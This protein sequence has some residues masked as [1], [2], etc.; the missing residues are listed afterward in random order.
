MASPKCNPLTPLF[1]EL[2]RHIQN[3]ELEKAQKI[4]NKILTHPNGGYT[5]QKA[6]QCKLVCLIQLSKFQ[7][8]FDFILRTEEALAALGP[9]AE[10]DFRA[11][12]LRGQILYRLEKYRD[13]YNLYRDLVKNSGDDY[14]EERQTNLAAC[15]AALTFEEGV[16]PDKGDTILNEET[17]ELMYNKATTLTAQGEY[18]KALMLLKKSEDMCRETLTEEGSNEEEIND[19]VSIVLAQIGYVNQKMGIPEA[20]SKYYN[21]V[22][23]NKPSDVAVVAVASNNIISL[24]REQN[25][26]DSKK[27]VKACI[28]ERVDAKLTSR[29]K[30][31]IALNN[32]LLNYYGH[33]SSELCWRL[34][35]QLEALSEPDQPGIVLLKAALF[36]RDRQNAKACQ[37]L[38]EFGTAHPS[39]SLATSLACAQIYFSNK[40]LDKAMQVLESLGDASYTAGIL[41][42]LISLCRSLNNDEQAAQ[43]FKRAIAFHKKRNPSSELLQSLIRKSAQYFLRL[44]KQQEAAA[45][46]QEQRKVDPHNAKLL[47][48]LVAAYATFDPAKAREVAKDLPA[49]DEI[50]TQVD[51]ASLEATNWVMGTR[52]VKRVVGSPSARSPPDNQTATGTA[53]IPGAGDRRK[54]PAK[55]KK[56]TKLPKN[57]D[58]NIV[59]DPERWLPR[60]ERSTFKKRGR[61]AREAAIGKGSQGAVGNV[62]E[63]D[64]SNRPTAAVQQSAQPSPGVGPRQQRPKAQQKKKKIGGKK[65]KGGW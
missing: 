65:G 20:A 52:H 2:H 6:I 24:N 13:S 34:M 8:A 39:Q 62:A 19:E 26:F 32:V 48:Q 51:V 53:A 5:N 57:Y 50:V 61:R 4:A 28:A 1:Q 35:R 9:A 30:K 46:L 18:Q 42:V 10:D 59:P 36:V 11:K 45:L 60:W 33:S 22:L 21:Q 41:G 17:Y 16:R 58:P 31:S 7:E 15:V 64:A 38:S 23:R 40:Q 44:G 3:S 55:K 54:V 14:D 63:L 25:I 43:I 27:K 12:E 56:K 29:Q 49:V 47:A 37:V